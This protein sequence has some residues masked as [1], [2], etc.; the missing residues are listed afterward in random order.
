METAQPAVIYA[1]DL[2]AKLHG[3]HPLGERLRTIHGALRAQL[4]FIDRV[5][6]ALYDGKT[7]VLKTFLSSDRDGEGPPLEHYEASLAEVPALQQVLEGGRPRIVN[8]LAVFDAGT[9]EHTRRIRERGYAASCAFPMFFRDRVAGCVFFNSYRRNCFDPG[10]VQALSPFAHLAS[11]VLAGELMTVRTLLAALKTANDMVH[12]KDPETGSHLERMSR[13]SRLIAAELSRSGQCPLNDDFIEHL[14]AFA[15][16]HDVGKIGIPDE[17]LLKPAR[18][19]PDEWE[20]MKTHAAKGRAMVDAILE[21]FGMESFEHVDVLRHVAE[22]HHEAVDGS[23][24]PHGLSGA[25]IPLAARIVAVADVFD[26]LTSRRPYKPAWSNDRA[27]GQ[28]QRLA[29]VKLDQDCVAALMGQR[30]A[31]EEIQRRFREEPD[32]PR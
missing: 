18:L 8:D 11:Q 4:E 13:F 15:P 32:A 5:A 14:F 30:E 19:D 17:V 9:R 25:E 10:A 2:L 28:L 20:V 31:V 6:V 22:H 21:N 3:R 16:L 26:A 12:Y 29:R 7:R 1:D 23:G 24:Y 27:F